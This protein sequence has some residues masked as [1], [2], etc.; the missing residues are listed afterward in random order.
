MFK[1]FA[2]RIAPPFPKQRA[3]VP[4]F[5]HCFHEGYQSSAL[6]PSDLGS[7]LPGRPSVFM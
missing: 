5:I 1:S 2:L 4:V 3:R 7:T 6:S